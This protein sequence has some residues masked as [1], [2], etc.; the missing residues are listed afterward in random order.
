[1]TEILIC[2]NCHEEI[3]PGDEP[4]RRGDSTYCCEA[5]A[6][7][8]GRSKDCG[9]RADSHVKPIVEKA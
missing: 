6:F 9:G 1:M 4:I 5:C 7:E 3:E 2:D 8:A